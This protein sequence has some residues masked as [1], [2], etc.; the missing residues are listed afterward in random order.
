MTVEVAVMNRMAVALAADSA[1]TVTSGGAAKIHNSAV[2]LLMLSKRHPVGVMVYNNASLLDVPWETLIKLFRRELGNKSFDELE[3]YGQELVSYLDDNPTLFPVEAQERYYLN[4]L[5]AEYSDIAR[6]AQVELLD[7]VQ[8]IERGSEEELRSYQIECAENAI[9]RRVQFWRDKDDADSINEALTKD[10]VGNF[11]GKISDLVLR[12][13][14]GWPLGSDSAKSLQELQEIAELLI[15]KDYFLPEWFSGVVIAGFGEREHFPVLQH[16]E[17]GSIYCNKLKIR[18]HPC[19]KISGTTS[20]IVKSFAYTEMIDTFLDGFTS[21]NSRNLERAIRLIR[22]MPVVAIDA[23]EGLSPDQR[24]RLEQKVR[25]AS[26]EQARQFSD[27][28]L[29]EC[30]RR[31]QEITQAIATLPTKDLAQVASTLVSLSSFQQR[32]SL[33]PETVGGP[34]DVAVISKGDGFIWIDRKHYFRRDLNQH[35]F[36][37]YFE[38]ASGQEKNDGRISNEETANA[39]GEKD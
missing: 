21:E 15:L 17:I 31:R 18:S 29:R 28:V 7:R 11:S 13:F 16:F 6:D 39:D 22:D 9:Q 35:F 26:A 30:F 4:T 34:V 38:D 5:G 33:E 19:E 10:F 3:M 27:I 8:Y 14:E 37:N 20:S 25:K 36:D 12:A 24:E 23:I 1:V 32:M 2:K